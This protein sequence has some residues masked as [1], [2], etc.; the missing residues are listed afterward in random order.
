MRTTA[1][2]LPK[3][4]RLAVIITIAA[5]A[6]QQAPLA[7]AADA[8][9]LALPA[10]PSVVEEQAVVAPEYDAPI[11]LDPRHAT[12]ASAYPSNAVTY[13]VTFN[14]T[15]SVSVKFGKHMVNFPAYTICDPARSSYG[16]ST[17]QS[18]CPKL[19]SHITI[20]ATTWT[21][22][23]GRPQI[24]FANA[25]RFTPNWNG[26]LPAIYLMDPTAS[27]SSWS[28]V[29]YCI[30]INGCINEA[31]TD[32]VLVTRRDPNSG[33]LYRLIRHFSGYNVWA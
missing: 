25:I 4:A 16:P 21:D 27:L 28:R 24:D 14:A 11:P 20:T 3:L 5:C 13:Q 19:T 7:P 8:T 23:K 31:L 30:T 15:S 17:W 6:E 12:M 22:S 18:S 10:A 26:Q 32:Q 29:D 2:R 9:E 1:K 33:W